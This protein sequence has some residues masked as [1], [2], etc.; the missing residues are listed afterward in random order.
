M[1]RL[2]RDPRMHPREAAGDPR[3]ERGILI[4]VATIQP[5][6][7]GRLGLWN[8]GWLGAP[9][10]PPPQASSRRG[11]GGCP[12]FEPT[13]PTARRSPDWRAHGRPGW[14]PPAPEWLAAVEGR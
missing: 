14:P 5:R 2:A 12:P 9:P 13:A 11:G 6:P 1:A 10:G 7:P 3:H 4:C 8:Q